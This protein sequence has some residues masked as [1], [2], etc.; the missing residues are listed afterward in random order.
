ML[1][2]G[3]IPAASRILSRHVAN[4]GNALIAGTAGA[5]SIAAAATITNVTPSAGPAQGGTVITVT[6]SRFPLTGLTAM[7]GGQS[8]TSIVVAANGNS[9]TATMPSHPAGGRGPRTR[10][11]ESARAS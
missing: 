3:A 8:L 9:F 6:G 1:V 10:H 7:L 2:V 4:S 11:R 5:Y